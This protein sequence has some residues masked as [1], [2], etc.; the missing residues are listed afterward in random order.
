MMHKYLSGA[1]VAEMLPAIEEYETYAS[2]HDN[3][4][5]DELRQCAADMREQCAALAAREVPTS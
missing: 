3:D 2:A 5:A 4:L 1:T